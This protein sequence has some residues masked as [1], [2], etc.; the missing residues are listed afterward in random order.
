MDLFFSDK[1]IELNERLN[2]GLYVVGGYVRDLLKGGEPPEDVDIAAA[3]D[4]QEVASSAEQTGFKVLCVYPRTGTVAFTDGQSRYEF[5]RFRSDVYSGGKHVPDEVS[6]TDDLDKDARRRDFKCNAIYARVCDG[7]IVDP[8]GGV[9]DVERGVL[10]AVT[11]AEKVF[12]SDGLRLMRLARFSGELGF[13]PT[14]AVMDAARRNRFKIADISKG[15]VKEEL[16]KILVADDKPPY[17]VKDGHY[18]ALK[19]LERTGVLDVLFP[20]LSDG[21]G[22]AQRADFHKYDVLEHSLKTVYY[23]PHSIRLAA[24]LH[25]IGKPSVMKRLGWYSGHEVVGAEITE[26]KL[27]ELKFDAR[28]IRK[29]GFLVATHMFDLECDEDELKVREFIVENY[30]EISDLLSLK[31]A[32]YRAGLDADD[33]C[34]TVTRWN[35]IIRRMRDEGA[36]FSARDLKI[37]ANDL[38]AIGYRGASIGEE[39]K[40]LL[41]SAVRG[42]T[43]NDEKSLRATAEA[44]FRYRQ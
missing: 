11:D 34:P 1:I 33:V 42:E 17:N 15:R 5:T 7:S 4:A 12:S 36:P 6:Y 35:E 3:I 24:L 14:R 43:K 18:R 28:T 20:E 44:D 32:D 13:E 30:A 22:M 19:V 10:D 8:L 31:Q 23:A 9:S 39:L 41:K 40:K 27:K 38:M 16:K 25:D 21:R 37:T 2:R 26:A 29:A